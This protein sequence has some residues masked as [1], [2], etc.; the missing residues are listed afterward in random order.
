MFLT[1][2]LAVGEAVGDTVGDTVGKAVGE[3]VVGLAVGDA[4]GDAVGA[5]VGATNVTLMVTVLCV[6]GTYTES[7]GLVFTSQSKFRGSDREAAPSVEPAFQEVTTAGLIRSGSWTSLLLT[8][9][10]MIV[11]AFEVTPDITQ[12]TLRSVRVCVC[13]CVCVCVFVCLCVC[14]YV[15]MYVCVCECRVCVSMC[16]CVS[17]VD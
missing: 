13:V 1:C 3:A 14:V 17:I 2:R 5:A 4:V 10:T 12:V 6:N 7:C 15:C 8:S 9:F 11:V 16:L